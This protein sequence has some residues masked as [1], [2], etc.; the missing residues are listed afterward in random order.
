VYRKWLVVVSAVREKILLWGKAILFACKS[1]G[2]IA[3]AVGAGLLDQPLIQ[4]VFPLGRMSQ[5][6][7]SDCNTYPREVRAA[8][9]QD[10]SIV[11]LNLI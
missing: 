7:A 3:G 11:V 8:S 2:N 1:R 4:N 6:L 5:M 10:C 9:L